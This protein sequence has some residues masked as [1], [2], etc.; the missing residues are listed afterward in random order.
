MTALA[1][2]ALAGGKSRMDKLVRDCPGLG[3]GD[4][5]VRIGHDVAVPAKV[6]EVTIAQVFASRTNPVTPEASEDQ[7]GNNTAKMAFSGTRRHD[8]QNAYIGLLAS[9]NVG[10]LG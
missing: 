6:P 8:W 9:I 7:H 1:P 3:D 2:F 10:E 4:G 5:T